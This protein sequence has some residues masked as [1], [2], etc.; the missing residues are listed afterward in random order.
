MKHN[1]QNWGYIAFTNI[2][3]I[4]FLYLP[5]V[6]Q[7]AVF[8]IFSL[9]STPESAIILSPLL[10]SFIFGIIISRIKR[11][12]LSLKSLIITSSIILII[13]LLLNLALLVAGDDYNHDLF[14]PPILLSI[15][16][17]LFLIFIGLGSQ[18]IGI[19]L[20][21]GSYLCFLFGLIIA[22]GIKN[23][24]LRKSKSLRYL[25]IT[26]MLSLISIATLF[27]SFNK[28]YLAEDIIYNYET[29]QDRIDLRDFEFHDPQSEL[30]IPSK[31]P[32]IAFKDQFPKID[33]A[34]ALF[35]IYASAA[36]AIYQIEDASVLS[37]YVRSSKT[38][39]AYENLINKNVDMIFVAEASKEQ[40]QLAKQKGIEL[41]FTPIG[42]EAFVFFVNK[43]NPVDSLSIQEI[44]SIYSGKTTHWK[45][46]NGDNEPILAF[47][48]PVNSGSQT[49]MQNRVMEGKKMKKPLKQEFKRGMGGII[50]AVADYRNASN[51]IGYSFRF[52]TTKMQ[53]NNEIKLL[54]INDIY[55]SVENI[56][57]KTYPFIAPFYIV[58]RK[59]VLPTNVQSLINWFKSEEG[60][61]LIEEVGYTR[62]T[63][64]TS[65]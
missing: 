35:P 33:G 9:P 27:Y 36:Q 7:S 1:I 12:S 6:S 29:L 22:S 58:T 14:L 46:L 30:T 51:S 45:D 20:I 11:N 34:T 49:I 42:I 19:A 55:P 21:A 61:N 53:S 44:Q 5:I 8:L 31:I 38:P 18:K 41:V 54:R 48:R 56:N 65:F 15:N 17:P 13:P 10:S 2:Y 57:N 43:T 16:F 28:Q 25:L 39:F 3:T 47:Q 62:Y 26:L 40:T 50:N 23:N 59:E 63:P 4:T 32:S 60:Q 64:S 37:Q 24:L 52:Y